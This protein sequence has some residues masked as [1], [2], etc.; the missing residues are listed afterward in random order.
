MRCPSRLLSSVLLVAA[1]A[2]ALPPASG[3]D[4]PEWRGPGAQGH[5]VEAHDLPLTWSE[6]ENIAWKTPL[7][8]R[9]WSSPVIAGDHIWMTTAI[10]SELSPEDRDR[11][12]AAIGSKLPMSVSGPVAL[13]AL[14]VD[15][16]TG[17][18]LH[19]VPLLVVADPQPIHALN[20]FASPTPVLGDGRLY[21][22]FGITD[23]P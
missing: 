23:C 17:R 19:D 11:R 14:C 9:G 1:I 10:E 4:W 15:R 3:A 5:A 22:H 13:H 6:T 16:E 12:L 2:V 7:P 20:S 18:L 8:G 21:C